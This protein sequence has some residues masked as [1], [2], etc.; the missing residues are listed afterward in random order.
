VHYG[1][2]IHLSQYTL[3]NAPSGMVASPIPALWDIEKK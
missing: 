3:P 2:H 1:T